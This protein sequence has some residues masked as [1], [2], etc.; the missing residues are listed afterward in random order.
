MNITIPLPLLEAASV[1]TVNKN[2]LRP[3]LTGV[4]L[5]DGYIVA[6]DSERLFYCPHSS[7]DQF[8]DQLI[9]PVKTIES[10][11]KQ[12]SRG[13]F[14]PYMIKSA[15]IFNENNE[16]HI[17]VDKTGIDEIFTPISSKFPSEWK[18][19]IPIDDGMQYKGTIPHFNWKHMVDFQKINKILGAI[20][21]VD[22]YLKPT[23][24]DS[25]AHIYFYGNNYSNA[26][27]L[28]MPITKKDAA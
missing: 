14:N 13:R 24:T 26:K 3:Y 18:R 6:T 17:V 19:V 4:V 9:I 20:N 10:I 25:A 23:G 8:K 12:F 1:C 21:P 27:G 15:H 22:T 16:Y 28:I 11:L 7:L 2:R 5:I